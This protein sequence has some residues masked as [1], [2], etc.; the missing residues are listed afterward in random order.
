MKTIIRFANEADALDIL[1]LQI[2]YHGQ[3]TSLKDKKE[4]GFVT[5]LTQPSFLTLL[6]RQNQV[7][8]C[9]NEDD[10]EIIG[11]ALLIQPTDACTIEFLRPLVVE[12]G[13]VSQNKFKIDSQ[14]NCII[15]GQILVKPDYMGRGIGKA[16]LQ[17]LEK[18]AKTPYIVTEVSNENPRSLAFHYKNNFIL[19]KKY[20]CAGQEF[21]IISKNLLF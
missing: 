14:A 4:R 17:K 18:S 13:A 10:C 2:K 5:L 9:S 21:N 12:I 15:L 20:T 7:A 8:V 11:Y 3:N 16:M 6:I 19:E 1:E